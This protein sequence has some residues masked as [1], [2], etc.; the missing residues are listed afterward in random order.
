M[1]LPPT[2]CGDRGVSIQ[3]KVISECSCQQ[4]K[5]QVLISLYNALS[6][7]LIMNANSTHFSLHCQD[8][9]SGS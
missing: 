5:T 4:L 7:V 8:L 3:P 1:L 6:T 9:E 2:W